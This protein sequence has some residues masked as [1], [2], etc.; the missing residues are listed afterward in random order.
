[1]L[2]DKLDKSFRHRVRVGGQ[3]R[4]GGQDVDLARWQVVRRFFLFDAGL[5]CDVC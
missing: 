2:D 4:H 5:V 1:V 3:W